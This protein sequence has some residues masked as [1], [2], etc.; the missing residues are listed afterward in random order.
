MTVQ[1]DRSLAVQS[2]QSPV[3]GTLVYPTIEGGFQGST[4]VFSGQGTVEIVENTGTLLIQADLYIL[5]IGSMPFITKKPIVGMEVRVFNNSRGSCAARHGLFCWYNYPGI[6]ADCQ[7]V[8]TDITNANGQAIFSLDP[9][10]YLVIGKYITDST[11]VY[12]GETAGQIT[13]GSVVKKQLRIIQS[14]AG[15]VFPCLSQIITGS[16]LLMIQPEY[17][18]WSGTQELYPFVFESVGDWSITTSVQ[19]P[20]GFVADNKSL[21]TDINDSLEAV[22]FTITDVG[23]KWKPT[24]VKYTIKHK[25]KI[26]HM[27][28]EI[29]VMLTSDLAKKKGV[30][31]YGE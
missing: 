16:E 13:T 19:P 1:F 28:S 24:K 10:N 6:W 14:A 8:D 11:T 7:P 20:E 31:I 22:Q 26:K 18:E 21:T 2:L 29:G 12:I 27:E 17:V 25:G 9:G 4:D 3:S 5:A 23:S 15:K 30:G